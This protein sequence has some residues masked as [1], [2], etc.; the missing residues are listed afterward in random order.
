MQF[1]KL[2][3]G[4][5]NSRSCNCSILHFYQLTKTGTRCVHTLGSILRLSIRHAKCCSYLLEDWGGEGGKLC[6]GWVAD[7]GLPPISFW[8]WLGVM[9]VERE[10]RGLQHGITFGS[11]LG[12]AVNRWTFHYLGLIIPSLGGFH[13]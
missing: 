13:I 2:P 1:L 12:R 10:R 7:S 5:G 6:N 11:I 8:S 4:H 3:M 9:G